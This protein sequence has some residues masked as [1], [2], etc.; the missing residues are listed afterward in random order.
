MSYMTRLAMTRLVCGLGIL[1][2]SVSGLAVGLGDLKTIS[3]LNEPFEARVEIVNLGDLDLDQIRVKLA[4]AEDFARVGTARDAFLLDLQFSVDPSN[5]GK[6]AIK[7]TSAQSVREP[8]LDFLVELRWPAGRILR[9]YT[10]LLDLPVFADKVSPRLAAS[11]RAPA[12][13]PA[14]EPGRST[15]PAPTRVPAASTEDGDG[16][17]GYRVRAG[18]T[19]WSIA[20]RSRASGSSIQQTMIAIRDRN[21]GA[22][23]DGDMNR[24]KRGALLTL[25]DA[26]TISSIDDRSARSQVARSV[27]AIQAR[28]EAPEL[29]TGGEPA[30]PAGTTDPKVDGVLTLLAPEATTTVGAG[31]GLS[32]E[33]AV[34]GDISREALENELAIAED[35]LARMEQD[36]QVLL[37]QVARQQDEIARMSRLLELEGNELAAI[38]Q[39]IEPTAVDQ[40]GGDADAGS[41][42]PTPEQP[43]LFEGFRDRLTFIAGGLLIL[44]L[45]VMFLLSRGRGRSRGATRMADV[46][47]DL[48][49]GRVRAV[50]TPSVVSAA[51]VAS[52]SELEPEHEPG[53]RLI[54]EDDEF[55]SDRS[56]V[57]PVGEADIYLSFG[58]YAEAEEVI[59]RGLET[60]P[61]DSRL[62]L[63]LL[64][65][66]AAQGDVERFDEHYPE[67]LA[68]GDPDAVRGA[69]R[70]REALVGPEDEVFGDDDTDFELDS[71]AVDG[72]EVVDHRDADALMTASPEEYVES[73][74]AADFEQQDDELDLIL[75]L[76]ADDLAVEETIGEMVDARDENLHLA[77]DI[78]AQAQDDS[79]DMALDDVDSE[80]DAALPELEITE[81]MQG[82]EVELGGLELDL[83][84]DSAE[85][86][87]SAAFDFDDFEDDLDALVGGDEVATQ[88][89]L[90]QAYVD[91]GDE[92]G[93]KDILKDVIANGS[94]AQQSEAEAILAEIS[95]A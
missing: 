33:P 34:G 90:A 36:N 18:D 11:A 74:S 92:A 47:A 67:L 69:E 27:A 50:G 63:K 76:P 48:E 51:A 44:I 21:P 9:N 38:Q 24:L 30:V 46:Q 37:E 85:S 58:D 68:L 65:V 64:D 95:R 59:R 45:G 91:M 17:G 28:N 70:M 94:E 62:H 25:P 88:L 57:D 86:E 1:I 78:A 13:R 2:Y 54:A 73:E 55:D 4:S 87:G 16:A 75:D 14:V 83:E 22:F 6:P 26:R 53:E 10:V 84:T 77:L 8:Y 56:N 42:A 81:K 61:Q 49:R 66:F 15:S 80:L 35:R 89:E 23:I 5:P 31:A 19:L 12:T 32:A 20:E 93:A 40:S 29:I 3:S 41:P 72:D 71:G 82:D 43:G 79:L 39:G 60:D 52:T 7:I